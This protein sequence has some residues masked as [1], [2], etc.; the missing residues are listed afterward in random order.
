MVILVI[1]A[2][3][4]LLIPV[5]VAIFRLQVI[6][7]LLLA[8]LVVLLVVGLLDRLVLL[9]ILRQLVM[10]GLSLAA[11]LGHALQRPIKDCQW[12]QGLRPCCCLIRFGCNEGRFC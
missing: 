2:T 5:L 12:G 4:G 1:L 8:I 11:I 3:Q 7:E 6:M 10:M 9:T